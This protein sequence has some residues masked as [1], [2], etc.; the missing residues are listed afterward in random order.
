M[1]TYRATFFFSQFKQ[2]WTETWFVDAFTIAQAKVKVTTLAPLLAASRASTVLLDSCRLTQV[3]PPPPPPSSLPVPLNINGGRVVAG[4]KLLAGADFM[5]VTATAELM[6]ANFDDGSTKA[7]LLRGLLD[8]DTVRDPV[9]GAPFPGAPL[10]AANA[11]L[12]AQ[13]VLDGWK[14]RRTDKTQIKNPTLAIQADPGNASLT[15]ITL[16]G[17]NINVVGD[18]VHFFKVPLNRVPWLKGIWTVRA[19]GA[20]SLSIGYPYPLAAPTPYANGFVQDIVYAYPLFQFWALEDFRTRQTGRPT[21]VTRG[22]SRG[23]RFR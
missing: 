12:A 13:L 16:P 22:R 20:N 14:G 21:L 18:R 10:V 2:G 8:S 19:I 5:D 9:T 1:P 15:Q 7:L 3:V 23:I 17:A 6:R 4:N 11:N